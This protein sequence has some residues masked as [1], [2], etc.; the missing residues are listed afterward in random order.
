M[1]ILTKKE[2]IENNI[3]YYFTGKPCVRGHISERMLSGICLSCHREDGAKYRKDNK[4]KIAE[5]HATYNKKNY[6]TVNRRKRYSKNIEVELC[7]AAKSRSKSKSLDFNITKD[8]III[9]IK[10]PV[11]GVDLDI[12]NKTYAP[13]LDRIDNTKGYIK[14]N[15]M[16]ISNKA[17]RLKNSGT[18]D[19]F[20]KILK[21]MKL[22]SGENDNG[23]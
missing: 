13:S 14:G 16:V 7:H 3:K 9:P 15:I 18:I 20:E 2:A 22:Y 1:N 19:D 11:Y 8:D 17:N 10:C 5:Y 12:H 4:T 21:Y 23:C 6:S